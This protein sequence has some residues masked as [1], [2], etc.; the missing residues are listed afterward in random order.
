MVS[1]SPIPQAHT[2]M[3]APTSEMTPARLAELDKSEDASMDCPRLQFTWI[4]TGDP[5]GP[6]ECLYTMVIPLRELD[7]RGEDEDGKVNFRKRKHLIIG[8]TR[9]APGRENWFPT[10]TFDGVT[11]V[12]TPFRDGAHALW[13]SEAFGGLP[14]YAV[15]NIYRTQIKAKGWC[16]PSITLETPVVTPS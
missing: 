5:E 1:E 16:K 15:W 12:N 11:T 10:T 2:S 8:V 6:W 13:D 14:V 3:S 4:R 9:C 7:I